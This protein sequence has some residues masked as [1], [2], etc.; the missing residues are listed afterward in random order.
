[1]FVKASVT[2]AALNAAHS[3]QPVC[4]KASLTSY[5]RRENDP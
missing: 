5:S 4:L 1:V 2:L 3:L